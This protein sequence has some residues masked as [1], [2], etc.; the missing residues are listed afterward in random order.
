VRQAI[1]QRGRQLLVAREDGHPSAAR[2]AMAS[3]WR[4]ERVAASRTGRIVIEGPDN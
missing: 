2:R 1:E 4:C 3:N